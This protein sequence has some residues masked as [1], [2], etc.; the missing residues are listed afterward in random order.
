MVP[1]NCSGCDSLLFGGHDI[2]G[3]DGQHGAVHRHR[4]RHLVEG[5]LVEEH[6]HVED[7]V[8]GHAGLADVAGNSLVVGVVAAMRGQVE[9]HRKALLSGGQIA[10]IERVRFFGGGEARILA[11]R[12]GL[13]DIHGAVR[14]A[15][16]GRDC[17][18]RSRGAPVR[19]GPRGV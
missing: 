8:D 7:G 17:R 18:R 2:E 15:Q 10:A 14:A 16:I 3:H 5:N 13:H 1:L 12:P 4:H 6:L 11:D 9:G 19:R